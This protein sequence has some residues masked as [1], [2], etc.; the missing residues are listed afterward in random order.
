MGPRLSRADEAGRTCPYC[1]F[2]LKA[3][4]LVVMCDACATIHHADCWQENSGCAVLGC[5]AAPGGQPS[6]QSQDGDSGQPATG[7][8]QSSDVPAKQQAAPVRSNRRN[9]L[10]FGAL[11]LIAATGVA[12]AFAL[13][14]SSS[15]GETTKTVVVVRSV[16]KAA[17]ADAA[18]SVAPRT[19]ST[20]TDAQAQPGHSRRA[21]ITGLLG[22]YY[23]AVSHAEFASA[24]RLLS[25]SYKAWKA[26]H[27]GYG[28]WLT[29]E[30]RNQSHLNPDGIRVRVVA[31]DP[32][33]G[34]ATVYV[35]GMTYTTAQGDCPYRGY[36]WARQFGSRWYYD[37]GY[38]QNAERA[39][40]WRPRSQ[41]TLGVPCES[42]QY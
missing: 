24:W 34:V 40:Q 21:L 9:A 35:S 1:R 39:A 42:D 12:V 38:L 11:A 14:R 5:S 23:Q 8:S 41:E 7:A 18:A 17:T 31:Y 3:Q 15:R 6:G 20:A 13:S 36:T 25:P 19:P 27:G 2:P 22:R 4:G 10:L 28:K 26:N 30:Q 29:S 37:Q 32:A 16:G 33:T